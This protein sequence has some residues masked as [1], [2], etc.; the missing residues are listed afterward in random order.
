MNLW[1]TRHHR[2]K[3]INVAVPHGC[4]FTLQN[5]GFGFVLEKGHPN[6]LEATSFPGLLIFQLYLTND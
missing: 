6:A 2:P 1:L 4:G 3:Q 5:R